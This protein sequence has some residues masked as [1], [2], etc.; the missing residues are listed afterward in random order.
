MHG[1]EMKKVFQA[2][3]G[4]CPVQLIRIEYDGFLLVEQ[5]HHLV[6]K[7]VYRIL[8]PGL[9]RVDQYWHPMTVPPFTNGMKS[10]S[11]PFKGFLLSRSK[12]RF[13]L[14]LFQNLD[15]SKAGRFEYRK[16]NLR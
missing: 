12:G 6:N 4:A 8:D 1:P 16:R 5:L 7:I 13:V 3:Q 14:H 15:R 10:L 9:F 2:S 11:N